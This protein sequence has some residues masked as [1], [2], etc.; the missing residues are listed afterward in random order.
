MKTIT[1]IVWT[2]EPNYY[3]GYGSAPVEKATL[4]LTRDEIQFMR[5]TRM[6]DYMGGEC[7]IS[8]AV[9]SWKVRV[10]HPD[11][12]ECFETISKEAEKVITE[13]SIIKVNDGPIQSLTIY[14]DDGTKA[15]V[16]RECY[17]F[18]E[19]SFLREQISIFLPDRML[20]AIFG[21][22]EEERE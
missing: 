16:S 17:I 9:E 20:Q 15:K 1:K 19:E 13:G 6:N 8:D 3:L 22:P 11:Y 5:K 12:P 2:E 4:T 14:Y 7:P 18:L 10:I 21:E